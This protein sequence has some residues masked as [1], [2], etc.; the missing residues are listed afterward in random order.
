MLSKIDEK[1]ELIQIHAVTL[2]DQIREK[3]V[4]VDFLTEGGEYQTKGVLNFQ[5]AIEIKKLL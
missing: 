1:Q 5:Y 4:I 2:K 3:L